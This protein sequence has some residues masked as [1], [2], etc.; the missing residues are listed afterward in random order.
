[1]RTSKNQIDDLV[2]EIDDRKEKNERVLITT[3]TIKMAEELTSYLKD[4]DIKV[5]YLHNEVNT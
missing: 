3:L 5:A 4:I 2:K 1:M